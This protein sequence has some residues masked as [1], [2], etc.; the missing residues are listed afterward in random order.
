[1]YLSIYLGYLKKH[2]LHY[3]IIVYIIYYNNIIYYYSIYYIAY[4]LSIKL[5]MQCVK[6]GKEI[7]E[8]K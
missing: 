6:L 7:D 2:M 3:I 1:M 8:M 5:I 4:T